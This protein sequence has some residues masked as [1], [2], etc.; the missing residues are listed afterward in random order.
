MN[1]RGG[2]GD[3]GYLSVS[4]ICYEG[5]GIC[6]ILLMYFNLETCK[7]LSFWKGK[8]INEKRMIKFP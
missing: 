4:F 8:G 3:D 2:I 5:G 1:K 6:K 7:I